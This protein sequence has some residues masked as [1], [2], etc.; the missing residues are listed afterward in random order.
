M[1]KSTG[2]IGIKEYIAIILLTIGTKLA[3]DLPSIIYN[4]LYNAAWMMP[5]ISGILVIIPLYL[6][7][8]TMMYYKEKSLLEIVV[9]LLGKYLGFI[10]IFALWIV[11]SITIIIDT[12]IYT[13]IIGTMYFSRTPTIILYFVLVGVCAYGAKRGI[14]QIGSVARALLPYIKISILIALILT[15]IQGNLDFLFPFFGPGEWTV[16]KESSLRLSIYGDILYLS[17]LTPYIRNANDFKKGTWIAFVILVAELTIAFFAYLLLFD[18]ESVRMLSYPF[19]EVIRYINFG[20]LT[21]VETFFFPFW[22]IATFVRFA[23]YFYLNGILFGRLFRIKDFEHVIPSLA[24]LFLLL[25]MILE[26]NPIA[27]THV[28][29]YLLIFVTPIFFGLPCI[30]WIVAKLKGDYKN[31]KT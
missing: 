7:I 3:D 25:G 12:A 24:T 15:M 9:H 23:V 1:E 2:K 27:L 4:S 6:L 16:I 28:R 10:V 13:D 29:D 11:G 8:K 14:E 26:N 30:L 18:F 21:N 19:H 31:E 20:F 17:L 22:L 5:I